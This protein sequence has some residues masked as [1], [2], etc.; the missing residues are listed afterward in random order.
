MGAFQLRDT[1]AASAPGRAA[2]TVRTARM[3]VTSRVLIVAG[4]GLV[5]ANSLFPRAMCAMCSVQVLVIAA[6]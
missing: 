1:V 3:T 6:S 2:A 5:E 4:S